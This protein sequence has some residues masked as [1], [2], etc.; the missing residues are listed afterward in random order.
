MQ[1]GA[2]SHPEKRPDILLPIPDKSVYGWLRVSQKVEWSSA[3]PYFS[4]T[5]TKESLARMGTSRHSGRK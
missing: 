5:T 1:Q 4:A 3:A 2:A